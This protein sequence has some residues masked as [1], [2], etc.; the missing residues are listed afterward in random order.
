MQGELSGRV[1][2]V[3]HVPGPDHAQTHLTHLIQA[4]ITEGADAGYLR[5]DVPPGELAAYSLHALTAAVTLTSSAA[6]SRLVDVTL[7]GLRPVP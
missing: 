4:L 5:Q 2:R 6:R 3:A 1:R 7:R